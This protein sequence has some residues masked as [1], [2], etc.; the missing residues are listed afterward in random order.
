MVLK[1]TCILCEREAADS[2]AHDVA[3]LRL[4]P[5]MGMRTQFLAHF[6]LPR[7][8]GWPLT[9]PNPDPC[10]D[11]TCLHALRPAST[12]LAAPGE[13]MLWVP[14]L[15]IAPL[16]CHRRDACSCLDLRKNKLRQIGQC[17][18]LR[19]LP[20][21]ILSPISLPSHDLQQTRLPNS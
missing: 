2:L 4:V 9:P 10:A 8:G 3:Q 11:T 7:P 18:V 19:S 17:R 1:S 13:L 16:F 14:F 15:H 5:A 12:L 20:K 6:T 21:L